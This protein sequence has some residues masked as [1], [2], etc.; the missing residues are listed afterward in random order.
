MNNLTTEYVKSIEKLQDGWFVGAVKTVTKSCVKDPKENVLRE[1]HATYK[2]DLQENNQRMIDNLKEIQYYNQEMLKAE[3]GISEAANAVETFHYAVR[4]LSAIVAT[5]FDATMFWRSIEIYC[6]K[7]QSSDLSNA[8]DDY[9]LFLSPEER[10]EEYSSPEFMVIFVRNLSQW[11]ALYSVCKEYK[12][13]VNK[14]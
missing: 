6:E 3:S 11:I 14:T 12:K 10:I 4:A 8:V 1:T 5:L 13:G 2:K 9:Q 7:A